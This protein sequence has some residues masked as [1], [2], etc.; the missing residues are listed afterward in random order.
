MLGEE[1]TVHDELD[2]KLKCNFNGPIKMI[3]T[4]DTGEDTLSSDGQIKFKGQN[5]TAHPS[6]TSLRPIQMETAGFQL[7][8]GVHH[9]S[10]GVRAVVA[11]SGI[12]IEA[13][14]VW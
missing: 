10:D 9:E 5:A 7:L 2:Q 6:T 1:K 14:R 11:S 4:Y 13:E 8:H 3:K 12:Q